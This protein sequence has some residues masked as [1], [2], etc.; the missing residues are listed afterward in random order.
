[1]GAEAFAQVVDVD[2]EAVHLAAT[3]FAIGRTAT[4]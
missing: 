4:G 3:S 1:M 2:D